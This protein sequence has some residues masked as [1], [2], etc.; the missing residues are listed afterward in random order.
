MDFNNNQTQLYIAVEISNSTIPPKMT[1]NGPGGPPM[2]MILLAFDADYN[3]FDE[4]DNAFFFSVMWNETDQLEMTALDT[5]LDGN[6]WDRDEE[7]PEFNMT[8]DPQQD[9][10]LVINFTGALVENAT[11]EYILEIS[12]PLSSGDIKDFSISEGYEPDYG[13]N[14][15]CGMNDANVGDGFGLDSLHV[16]LAFLD[17]DGD[18][19]PD[20]W[21]DDLGTNK[22]NATDYPADNDGDMWPDAYDDDDDDDGYS[23]ADEIAAG[24]DPMDPG[25]LPPDM[26]GDGIPDISDEDMDGDG[27]SNWD[28][29]VAGT[30]PMDPASHP[31][32][33]VGDLIDNGLAWL[34]SVQQHDGSWEGSPG[35]TSLCL[36]AFL[37]NN[38]T[39]GNDTVDDALVYLLGKIDKNWDANN[40]PIGED[41]TYSVSMAILALKATMNGDYQDEIDSLGEWLVAT[42]W[43][44]DNI[45]G[46]MN[47]SDP[48]YGGWRYGDASYDSDLSVTQWAL[49]GLDAWGNLSKDDP[50]W[51]NALSF[52]EAC[53]TP[54]GG[55]VYMPHEGPK[56]RNG[57]DGSYGSMS[58]AGLWSLMLCGLNVSDARVVAAVDW[59]KQNYTWKENAY[60]GDQWV[61]YYYLTLAKAL[62]MVGM[63][64]IEVVNGTFASDGV[65]VWL[66]DMVENLTAK[67]KLNESYWEGSNDGG[68][69]L[70]TAYSLLSL[71]TQALPEGA[72]LSAVF[73]L[74]S[75]ATLHIY[76]RDGRHVGVV[77]GTDKI[78]VGIPGAIFKYQGNTYSYS[79]DLQTVEEGQG[80]E[81]IVLPIAEAGA[82]TLELVGIS[83]GGYELEIE[84]YIGEQGTGMSKYAGTIAPGE[85][86]STN[87]VVTAMEGPLTIFAQEPGEKPTLSISPAAIVGEAEPGDS[88][89]EVLSFIET[90]EIGPIEDVDI[91]LGALSSGA[92]TIPVANIS[93]DEDEFDV[94]AGATKTVTFTIDVPVDQEDGSYVGNIQV[95]RTD[96]GI[97]FI[98]VSLDVE[99]IVYNFQMTSPATTKEVKPGENVTY[100]VM[101]TNLANAA[102]VIDIAVNVT[103]GWTV[104]LSASSLS[105]AESGMDTLTV[106]VMAPTDAADDDV[107]TVKLTATSQGLSSLVKTLDL[108][109]TVNVTVVE[110][111]IDFTLGPFEYI[112]GDAISGAT[113]ELK[114]ALNNVTKKGT[115]DTTGKIS[116]RMLPALLSG[117]L[118]KGTDIEV[119]FTLN[120]T[121][122]DAD[123]T[124]NTTRLLNWSAPAKPVVTPP[125]ITVKLGP[126][127]DKDGNIIEGAT[128]TLKVGDVTKTGT[129]DADGFV[130]F[131]IDESLA[132][133]EATIEFGHADY[134]DATGKIT[135]LA[136]GTV[137]PE[138]FEDWETPEKLKGEDPDD[139]GNWVWVVIGIVVVVAI[140]AIVFFMVQKKKKVEEPLPSLDE[141]G[142]SDDMD[143]DFPEDEDYDDEAPEDDWD[144]EE[145]DDD[146]DDEEGDDDWDDEPK[147]DETPAK[148]P[149][150]D[151]SDDYDDEYDDDDYDDDDYDDEDY[152]DED[153]EFYD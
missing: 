42:Q 82:Y 150:G 124:L 87:V 35:T 3:G 56:M 128:I 129:T 147:D 55:F 151:E 20:L 97:R 53:Q 1:R 40:T 4:G 138:T 91:T 62:T 32:I 24:S 80:E 133:S 65:H 48:N 139:G 18:G 85:I 13:F 75:N 114:D 143:E 6:L 22:T 74:H 49:M 108:V 134:P 67:K 127:E 130:E 145:G 119:S 121:D 77:L 83:T 137:G 8:G 26:D 5:F 61:Y 30:D 118:T 90:S 63:E 31:A 94:A 27:F 15:I 153:D 116:F 110:P 142:F 96:G 59:L 146:W 115:T 122:L 36:L 109:T 93:V 68:P 152:D 41:A 37:N 101:V 99:T 2:D 79:N 73:T 43:D 29:G 64:T 44:E 23:D 132:G 72:N 112:G 57:H 95:E 33:V 102:D 135:T 12:F 141:D 25:S 89:E 76:D 104:N 88:F 120:L 19:Y 39:E 84:G 10:E 34:A 52:V 81:Q 46:A 103:A 9:G 140:L 17:T 106:I 131:K 45:W 148:E 54:S 125:E 136:A 78:E 60:W 98:P 149:A 100:S 51:T 58:A 47:N 117:K 14:F 70:T 21:E 38:I 66:D 50:V 16:P 144:D 69:E 126:F 105:L 71:E 111:G 113:V 7:E 107:G 92:N 11:G 28:E 123:K 86:H